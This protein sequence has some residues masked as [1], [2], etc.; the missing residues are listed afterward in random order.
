[1]TIARGGYGNFAGWHYSAKN[2]EELIR[3]FFKDQG[4][5]IDQYMMPFSVAKPIA[6]QIRNDPWMKEYMNKSLKL[7]PEEVGYLERSGYITLKK[8][9]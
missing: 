3:S 1:M 2:C 4:Y 5:E 6:I 8:V 9:A 7:L